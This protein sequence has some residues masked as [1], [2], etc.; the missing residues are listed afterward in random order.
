L[1]VPEE[2][3]RA[4][5]AVLWRPAGD[6][7]EVAVV[8]RPRYDDWSLPKGKLEDD[9]HPL[10]AAVREVIEETGVRAH[11][12]VRLPDVAYT[13]PNGVPKTVE[14]WS[15]RADAGEAVPIAD[16]HEVDEVRWLSPER[17]ADRLS[18]PA[19][20]RL[21]Q[22]V[23][24]L[25][26]VTAVTAVVRHGNAGERKKWA[27]NDAVRP[28]DALGERQAA[29]LA[30]VLALFDPRRLVAATPLRCRQTLEPLAAARG[31]AIVMDSAFTEPADAADLPAKVA[32]AATRLAELHQGETTVVCSQG[33]LIPPTLAA[34]DRGPDPAAYKTPKGGGWVLSWSGEKPPALS[35]L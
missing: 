9:E 16:P 32:V 19:D 6:G 12:Q 10:V 1:I 28:I 25:P 11:P 26:P 34:L 23:D 22:R 7:I 5:G 21:V 8:H 27:G 35:R 29:G 20:A 24:D 30:T 4:A 15:M 3:V 14:F 31:L 18:Y 17:A 2:T 13:L 33:K